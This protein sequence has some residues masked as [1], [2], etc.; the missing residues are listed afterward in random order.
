MPSIHGHHRR[1]HSRAQ[2]RG[3]FDVSHMGEISSRVPGRSTCYNASRPTTSPNF[4]TARCSTPACPTA[5][6]ASSTASGLP[7][8][9]PKPTVSARRNID[10]DWKH[11]CAEGK[12]FGMEAGHGRGTFTLRTKSATGRPGPLAMKIVQKMCAEPVEGMEYYTFKKMPVAG[13][14]AILSI[15]GY[16][17]SGRLRDLRRQRRRRE[18]TLEGPL[19]GRRG[20]RAGE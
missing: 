12:A 16:T 9:R 17:G 15:T 3:V 2:R 20:V 6:G 19:G 8:R 10:K 13:C 18:R 1:A 11:I 7:H 5:A 14:D 4:S